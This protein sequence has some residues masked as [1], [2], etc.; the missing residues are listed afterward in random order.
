M[1]S[2]RSIFIRRTNSENDLHKEERKVKIVK[3][4]PLSEISDYLSCETKVKYADNLYNYT[5][6]T[7]QNN[8]YCFASQDPE[9]YTTTSN[10][11]KYIYC[12]AEK[13]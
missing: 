4:E 5:S 11:Q 1:E 2:L 10:D 3:L 13:K 9:V 7:G 6:I 12:Y 8:S